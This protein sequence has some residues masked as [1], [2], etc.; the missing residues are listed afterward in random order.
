MKL[1]WLEDAVFDL[2]EIRNYIKKDKP[3]ASKSI[4]KKIINSTNDL[5]KNP[6]I[7]RPGRISGTRE[8]IIPN[9]PF[10]IPYRVKNNVI[11]V[12]RVFHGKRKWP[13]SFNNK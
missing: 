2:K 8:L 11:E 6:S 5:K 4:S 9:T 7:G 1:I 10:L 3:S 13:E 12:L